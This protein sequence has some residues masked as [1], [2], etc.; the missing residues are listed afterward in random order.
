METHSGPPFSPSYSFRWLGPRKRLGPPG[1]RVGMVQ[2]H[3]P[4][5]GSSEEGPETGSPC[6]TGGPRADSGPALVRPTAVQG[7]HVHEEG[8]GALA[9]SSRSHSQP[10]S[11]LREMGEREPTGGP[12]RGPRQSSFFSLQKISANLRSCSLAACDSSCKRWLFCRRLATSDCSTALSCFSCGAGLASAGGNSGG[13][14]SAGQPGFKSQL[15][16]L[17]GC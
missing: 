2:C 9:G 7:L 17:A 1:A 10:G 16:L 6:G 4:E 12:A 8:S 11:E 15:G 14:Q 5:L 13:L 3:G